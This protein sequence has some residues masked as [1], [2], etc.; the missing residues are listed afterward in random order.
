MGGWLRRGKGGRSPMKPTSVSMAIVTQSYDYYLVC[1]VLLTSSVGTLYGA[2]VVPTNHC[3]P[4][5]SS[6]KFV[7]AAAEVQLKYDAGHS[8]KEIRRAKRQSIE[9]ANAE[10]IIVKKYGD[11]VPYQ[12]GEYKHYDTPFSAT[13]IASMMNQLMR[14]P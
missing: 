11:I 5:G 10:D 8:R 13:N 2:D 4:I 6:D 9:K 1:C 12:T 14:A 3:D 7:N